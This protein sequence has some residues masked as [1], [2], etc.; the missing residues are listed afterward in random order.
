MS[1]LTREVIRSKDI[2][3]AANKKQFNLDKQF[4][5]DEL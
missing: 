3:M 5:R 1:N 2:K 4:N